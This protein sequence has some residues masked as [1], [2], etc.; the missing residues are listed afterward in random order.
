MRT[1]S[2][3]LLVV[4]MVAVG[5]LT[6]LGVAG[7]TQPTNESGKLEELLQERRDTLR[8]LVKVVTVEFQEGITGFESV[9]RASDQLIDAELELAKNT[10]ARIAILQRRVELLKKLFSL[11]EAKFKAGRGTRAQVLATKA[12][13]LEAQIDLVREQA[14][15]ERKD[16]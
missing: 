15:G 2:E 12:A 1:K 13:L 11:T 9:C 8:Q 3:I 4:L 16:E 14:G 10:E 6:P 5:V 7:E